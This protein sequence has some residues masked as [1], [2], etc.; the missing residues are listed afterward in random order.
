MNRSI[1]QES[2]QGTRDSN[3]PP[4]LEKFSNIHAE[5]IVKD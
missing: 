5:K 2:E 1:D 3:V 4:G